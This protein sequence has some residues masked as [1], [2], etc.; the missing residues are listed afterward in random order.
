MNNEQL[1]KKS[2]IENLDFNVTA[3]WNK[4]DNILQSCHQES[5]QYVVAW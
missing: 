2:V 3:T 5:Y 1:F 4:D